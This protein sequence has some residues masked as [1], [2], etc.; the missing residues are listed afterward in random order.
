MGGVQNFLSAF[1]PRNNNSGFRVVLFLDYII[2]VQCKSAEFKRIQAAILYFTAFLNTLAHFT[3]LHNPLHVVQIQLPPLFWPLRNQNGRSGPTYQQFLHIQKHFQFP[4]YSHSIFQFWLM[5]KYLT[6]M[7]LQT[8]CKSSAKMS[9]RI[10]PFL[11]PENYNKY[12][13][14][15]L[16]FAIFRKW[17][18]FVFSA[19]DF[20][21]FALP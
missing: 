21:F 16:F 3:L 19:C 11:N 4:S 5:S 17:H 13:I 20:P 7:L 9:Y 15:E 8:E 12:H 18:F 10:F 1:K 6:N 2:Q 14:F